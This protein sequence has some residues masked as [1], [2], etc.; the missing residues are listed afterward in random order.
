MA[1]PNLVQFG[2]IGLVD[3]KNDIPFWFLFISTP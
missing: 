2:W 3:S 1:C